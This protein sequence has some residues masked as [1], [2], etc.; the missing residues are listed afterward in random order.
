MCVCLCVLPC[1][2]QGVRVHV[3]SVCVTMP[4]TV[5]SEGVCICYHAYHSEE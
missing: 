4:T 2:P 3:L 1:L 5:G